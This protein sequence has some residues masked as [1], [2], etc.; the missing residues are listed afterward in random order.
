MVYPLVGCVSMLKLSCFIHLST[1]RVTEGKEEENI[2]S[3]KLQKLGWSYRPLEETL[4]DSVEGYKQAGL[5]DQNE[6]GIP[7]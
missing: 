1:A 5:L 4:V 2:S 3:E 7:L 6:L